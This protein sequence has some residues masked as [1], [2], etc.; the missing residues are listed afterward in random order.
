M[1][2]YLV[3]KPVNLNSEFVVISYF[4]IDREWVMRCKK[5]VQARGFPHYLGLAM[6]RRLV[7][8]VNLFSQKRNFVVQ[9]STKR[10]LNLQEEN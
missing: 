4:S 10:G 9:G 3:F 2:V 7:C 8:Q 1:C 6:A 5:C